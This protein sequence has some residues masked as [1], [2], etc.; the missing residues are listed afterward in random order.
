MTHE[1]HFAKPTNCGAIIEMITQLMKLLPESH[2][3]F[4]EREREEWLDAVQSLMTLAYGETSPPK[5][6]R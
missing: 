4:P 1:K 2:E 5:P 6:A 3:P